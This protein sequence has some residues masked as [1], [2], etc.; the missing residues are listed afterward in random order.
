MLNITN[1]FLAT[2]ENANAKG[3]VGV[4]IDPEQNV[5]NLDFGNVEI[6]PLLGDYNRDQSV[7]AADYVFWRKIVN[8]E[9]MPA[10][11]GADGDGN[12]IVDDNDYD[13]WVDQFGST[14]TSG[15]GSSA[16][17][18]E[19][20]IQ[21]AAAFAVP[22][23]E[24]ANESSGN[25]PSTRGAAISAAAASVHHALLFDVL[26]TRDESVSSAGA[27]ARRTAVGAEDY[28]IVT[29]RTNLNRAVERRAIDN[30]VS[31][32]GAREDES[33]RDECFETYDALFAGVG[34]ELR[35]HK[36]ISRLKALH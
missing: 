15:G 34:S 20:L 7:D 22:P 33:A 35:Q 19:A 8:T 23:L 14:V 27:R 5:E 2:V 28:R 32:I 18:A 26:E 29:L 4:S 1:A 17:D 16:A 21:T 30:D 3:T 36:R 24:V 12:A 9:V 10:Y 11:S 13:V 25:A 31:D 6:Q